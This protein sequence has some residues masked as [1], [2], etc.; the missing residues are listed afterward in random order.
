MNYSENVTIIS[1]TRGETRLHHGMRVLYNH[2]LG[3]D[4]FSGD[5]ILNNKI[6]LSHIQ[7]WLSLGLLLRIQPLN[8][9]GPRHF[10]F[11]QVVHLVDGDHVFPGKRKRASTGSGRVEEFLTEV[12]GVDPTS[13]P[14]Q[15]VR[16]FLPES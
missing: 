16:D 2:F 7:A 10:D 6:I 3:V 1:L 9:L 4:V 5:E 11:A 13:S 15:T 12:T 14:G 8:S